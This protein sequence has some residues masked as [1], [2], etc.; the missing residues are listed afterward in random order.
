MYTSDGPVYARSVTECISCQLH[1]IIIYSVGK[2][3]ASKRC[4]GTAVNFK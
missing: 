2:T 3:A 1:S 4:C